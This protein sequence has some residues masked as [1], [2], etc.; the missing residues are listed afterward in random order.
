MLKELKENLKITEDDE[1]TILEGYLNSSKEY[2]NYIAGIDIDFESSSFAKGLLI[3]RCRYQYNNA[4]EY[5]EI[6]FKLDLMQLQIMFLGEV[7]V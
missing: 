1:D 5:F 7:N 6:N 4:V 2:L 3:E